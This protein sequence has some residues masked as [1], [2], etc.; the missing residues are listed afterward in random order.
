V[1][2]RTKCWLAMVVAILLLAGGCAG[3]L[4]ETEH[5]DGKVS[6]IRIQGGES[7]KSY[8]KNPTK[9][10]ESSFILKKEATF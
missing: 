3:I 1:E 10:D 9:K 4:Q 7:W 6:R 8:D 2:G 5:D